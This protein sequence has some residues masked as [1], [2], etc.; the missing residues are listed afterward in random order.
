MNIL[1]A[2]EESQRVCC[3]FREKGHNA[4]SCDILPCSGGHNEW[5]I[6]QDV[7]PLVN[8]NCKF[9]TC[10]GKEHA[11]N[12]KW[13]MIIAFPPCYNLCNS[14]SKWFEKKRANGSQAESI[15]FFCVFLNADC[16]KICIE[17]PVG[18]ISGNYIEKH[19]PLLCEK[20]NLPRMY[21]QIIQPY[22]FSEKAQ[23]KTCLWLKNLPK[24][25]P[26]DIVEAEFVHY[27]RKDGKVLNFS[28]DYEQGYKRKDRRIA[29]SKTYIGVANAMA[30]QWG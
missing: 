3:A 24:L 27:T 7:R 17:N 10:D 11:I 23:K 9:Y 1:V 4:F 20:Y 5:H 18:I 28:K 22:W 8:G 29:R 30:E 19:F 25:Q 6:Q 13:D 15:E 14:G 2:C 21:S 12:G 16:E 26:T